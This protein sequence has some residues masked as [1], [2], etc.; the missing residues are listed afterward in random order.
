MQ[1]S[2]YRTRITRLVSVALLIVFLALFATTALLAKDGPVLDGTDI[3][4]AP[5]QQVVQQ[6]NGL[7]LNQLAQSAGFSQAS[8]SLL[9]SQGG[10]SL[11]Q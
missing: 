1:Q 11:A 2:T 9:I 5:V 3:T 7:T 6:P 10:L 8:K 4:R